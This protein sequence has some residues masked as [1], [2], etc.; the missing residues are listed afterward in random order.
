MDVETD[1]V[2]KFGEFLGQLDSK[3]ASSSDR[4]LNQIQELLKVG[5]S[6]SSSY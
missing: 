6:I 2:S 5:F 3:P 1:L 4:D